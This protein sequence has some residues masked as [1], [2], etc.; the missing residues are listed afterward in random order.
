MKPF[1]LSAAVGGALLHAQAPPSSSSPAVTVWSGVYTDAQAKRGAAITAQSCV[2]CHGIDMNSGEPGPWLYGSDFAKR[3][4]GA[5]VAD[6]VRRL[7]QMPPDQPGT[8]GPQALADI[9]AFVLWSN[10]FPVGARELPTD[11]DA[12]ARIAIQTKKP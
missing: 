3:Y 12:L 2:G 4:E 5:T 8:L 11:T 7:D 6:L 10:D 9:A 1:L